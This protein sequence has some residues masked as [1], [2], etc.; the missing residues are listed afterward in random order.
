[1]QMTLRW[2]GA[3]DPVSLA[4]ILQ[5]PRIEGI[6]T[7]LHDLPAGEVWTPDLLR[8]HQATVEAAG[9]RWLVAESIPV[10]ESIK[11]GHPERDQY[12]E[13]YI[14]SIRNLGRVGVHVLC[15]NFMP[16]FDW[17]RT[18]FAMPLPDQ[19]NA[20]QYIE[21]EVQGYDLTSGMT[22]RIAW[23]KG[24]TGEE[25][26]ELLALYHE[27]SDEHLFENL[28]YFLQAVVPA[29]AEADVKLAIHPDDPPWS[30]FGLPRI[31]RTAETIQRILSTVDHPY[32]GL[33]F[34]TGSLGARLD[35]DLPAMAHQ[36][37]GRIHFVHA[38][39]VKHTA[40][41][42]FYE[43]AHPPQYG[44]VDLVEVMRV[45]VEDGF[46]GPIRPDHGRMIWGETGIPGYGLYDRAL[47]AM[48]LQGLID[49]YRRKNDA[50]HV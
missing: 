42:D 20:M 7:A 24:Y 25:I 3:D 30:I 34:C 6:V 43:S 28:I 33:T 2:F 15:Y 47:G 29:A 13:N 35:N 26:A 36:F 16:V 21:A 17:M 27:I 8:A 49:G 23:A 48:Y 22:K 50:A 11:L 32:N 12:I 18:N 39:N 10:H 9:A 38:R 31:V 37:A 44:D 41:R 46:T 19:S 5:I 45:L 4:A 14:E 40:E 1:M